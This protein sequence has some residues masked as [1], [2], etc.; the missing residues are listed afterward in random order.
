MNETQYRKRWIRL[1]SRYEKQAY[2]I[3][4]DEFR[5]MCNNIPF[6]IVN[7]ANIELTIESSIS[8]ENIFKTFYKVYNT[9]GK[10]HAK[11]VGK[12]INIQL[13]DFSFD[14]F[15]SEWERN[16]LEWL[17]KNSASNVISVR[18]TLIEYLKQV[19]A[20]GRAEGKTISEIT[21]DLQ[22]LIN[23]RNFYRYQALRIARTETTS[24]AN[25]ATLTSSDVSGVATDKVWVSAQD[26]R[27]R[28]PP[29]SE[30]NHLAMNG[31]RIPTNEKFNVNGDEI[32]F[33]GD[34]QGDAGNVINCRCNIAIVVRR[35]KNGTIIRT[36]GMP[37]V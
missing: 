34:P 33:P 29:Q 20:F 37:I 17:F 1:H 14:T 19:I 12:Q 31:V 6:N 4:V 10:E 30:F 36:N 27:T 24:A 7:D 25:Y 15:L 9:I 18:S 16:L 21:T 35:D 22:R 8:K 26:A 32:M 3:F 2:K 23:S 28:K 11:Y 13:K 5:N